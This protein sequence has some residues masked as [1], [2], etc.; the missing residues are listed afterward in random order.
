MCV[1]L[2]CDQSFVNE[3]LDVVRIIGGSGSLLLACYPLTVS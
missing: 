1:K 2:T 3:E